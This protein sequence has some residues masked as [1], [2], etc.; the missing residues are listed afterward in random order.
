[1]GIIKME[2]VKLLK[3][4]IRPLKKELELAQ[5][6]SSLKVSKTKTPKTR[7]SE[8]EHLLRTSRPNYLNWSGAGIKRIDNTI[9]RN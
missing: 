2:E 5:E 1:M 4:T 7:L 8:V 3:S 6:N 9:S